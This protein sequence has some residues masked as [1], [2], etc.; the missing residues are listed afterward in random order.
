MKGDL[1]HCVDNR[2]LREEDW[3]QTRDGGSDVV[4]SAHSGGIE[5]WLDLGICWKQRQQ[6]VLL[7]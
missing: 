5:M 7:D 6:D 1:G 2:L 3:K 4:Q